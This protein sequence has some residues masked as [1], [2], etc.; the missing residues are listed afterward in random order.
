V[1]HGHGRSLE[2]RVLRASSDSHGD[3]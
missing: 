3:H 1:T 2:D